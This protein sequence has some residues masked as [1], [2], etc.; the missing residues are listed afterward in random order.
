MHTC[1]NIVLCYNLPMPNHE[2]IPGGTYASSPQGSQEG[3]KEHHVESQEEIAARLNLKVS[4]AFKSPTEQAM[5]AMEDVA[6]FADRLKKKY[7][8][9][10]SYQLFHVLSLSS[11]LEGVAF[12]H[13]DFPGEDSV[14]RFIEML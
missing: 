13:F 8:D 6:A 1:S 7:P 5:Q 2:D 9:Y 14:Q 10:D 12:A 11:Q 3:Q 4:Q